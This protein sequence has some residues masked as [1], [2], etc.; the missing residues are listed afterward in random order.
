MFETRFAI[1]EQLIFMFDLYQVLV[2]LPIADCLHERFCIQKE[3]IDVRVDDEIDDVVQV[4]V[5]VILHKVDVND[6]V[7]VPLVDDVVGS[8]ETVVGDE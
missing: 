4:M 2:A 3:Q 1:C 8:D 5:Q 7:E 6:V